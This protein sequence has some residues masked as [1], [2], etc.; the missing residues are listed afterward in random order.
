MKNSAAVVAFLIAIGSA[1]PAWAQDKADFAALQT[2][3]KQED[4]VTLTTLAGDKI[5]GR[6]IEVSA[7]RIVLRE[8]G[9]PRTVDAVQIQ[10]VQK[11]KNGV[12]LGALIGGG[13]MIPVSI[14][15]SSYNYNEGGDAGVALLPIAA[16]L[17]AGIGIDAAIGSN[18]TLYERKPGRTVTVAPLIDRKGGVGGR[19]AFK[20]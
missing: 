10:K 3:L 15:L 14:A 12:L 2:T 18:K 9:G 20:F 19:I 7:D 5:K 6:M 17:G 4:E 11:R 8:K 1:A 16:G 13:A